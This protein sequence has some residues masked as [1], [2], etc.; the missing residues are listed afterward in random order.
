MAV[1]SRFFKEMHEVCEKYNKTSSK[2]KKKPTQNSQSQTT[3]KSKDEPKKPST[4]VFMIYFNERRP[5]VLE[6]HPG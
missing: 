3:K 6:E 2:K 5:K 1:C 4:N